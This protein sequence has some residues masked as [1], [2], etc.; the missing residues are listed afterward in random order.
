ML[1]L[2][3]MLLLLKLIWTD[4]AAAVD[5]AIAEANMLFYNNKSSGCR[6]NLNPRVSDRRQV[7]TMFHPP[8]LIQAAAWYSYTGLQRYQPSQTSPQASPSL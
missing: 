1:L 5:A 2:L 4:A 8:L 6:N 3:L 7:S